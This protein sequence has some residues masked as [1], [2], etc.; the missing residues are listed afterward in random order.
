[1][2]SV[3]DMTRSGI[4]IDQCKRISVIDYE[5]LVMA[6]CNPINGDVLIAKDGATCLDT[7][8]VYNQNDAIVLLSSIALLRPGP[9]LDSFFLRYYFEM[10]SIVRMLKEGYVSGSVVPRV[11]LQDFKRA[12]IVLP[13]LSEQRAIAH[14]LST[15]DDK[16]EL[17]R[18]MNETLEDIAR[19]LFKSWFIDFDPVRAKAEGRQPFG[20]NEETASLFPSE[21]EDSE[22]GEIPKGWMVKPLDEVADFLNGLA[23]QKYPATSEDSLPVIKIAELNRG[24]NESTSR[25]S[26]DIP[27]EY[28]VENG[29]VLFSWSGSLE[30]KIWCVAEVLSTSI[31]SRLLRRNTQNGSITTG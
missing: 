14:I 20:M 24:I 16:I 10:P 25:A 13:P 21:F 2:A 1:M 27:S 12:P 31:F 22:L 28:V 15:L 18:R 17:N 6:G 11:I 3:K 9:S 5:K 23:M 26:T 29:D 8:C 7:V 30:L 19:A 4:Q